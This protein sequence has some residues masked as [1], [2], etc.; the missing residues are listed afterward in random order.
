ME[1]TI[2]VIVYEL[3]DGQNGMN[4]SDMVL[5]LHSSIANAIELIKYGKI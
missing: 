4:I 1:R 3:Y 5:K 2:I